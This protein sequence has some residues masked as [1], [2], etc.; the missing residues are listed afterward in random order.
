MH[1]LRRWE[2]FKFVYLCVDPLTAK[3][4]KYLYKSISC[5]NPLIL[6]YNKL[7]VHLIIDLIVLKEELFV[8][9]LE[10]QHTQEDFEWS[11]FLNAFISVP[12]GPRAILSESWYY[13][14]RAT[15]MHT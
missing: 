9:Q 6:D 5:G 8:S 2:I 11:E 14:P 7:I 1:S 3:I 13:Q 15:F 12:G 4:R 10:T